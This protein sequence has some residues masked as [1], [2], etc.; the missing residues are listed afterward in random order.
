M[1][2]IVGIFELQTESSLPLPSLAPALRVLTPRGPDGEGEWSGHGCSLGHRRLSIL[3]VKGG[4]QP[5]QDSDQSAGV[6]TYNGELYNYRALRERLAGRGYRFRSDCDT[7]VV[8]AAWESD[9]VRALDDFNGIFAFAWFDGRDRLWLVRD[10]LGA[11]PLYYSVVEGRLFFAST[12]AALLS[13]EEIPRVLDRIAAAH[14]LASARTNLDDR[15]LL[16]DIRILPPGHVLEVRRGQRP[17]TIQPRA[18]W[19]LPPLRAAD[20][21]ELSLE[22]AG[23]ACRE[24][25]TEAVQRQLQSDVPVGAFLSGGLD[26]SI[27]LALSKDLRG[28]SL[29]SYGVEFT[30]AA[31]SE[32]EGAYMR[33]AATALET[34][35]HPVELQQKD[36]SPT[37]EDL[38]GR[39]GL[40]LSTPNEVAIYHLARRLR[41]EFTV[42][43][44][45]EGADEV[46]AGYLLPY[47][48]AWDYARTQDIGYSS[49]LRQRIRDFYG[50]SVFPHMAAHHLSLNVW[51]PPET[52]VG[53]LGSTLEAGW[54]PVAN[55]YRQSLNAVAECS[56][57][58]RYLHLHRRVN[59]EGLLLRLDANTMAAS[60]EGRVPFADREIVEWANTLPDALRLHREDCTRVVPWR[61]HVAADWIQRGWVEGKRVLRSAFAERLP[62]SIVHRPK[63]SFPVPFQNELALRSMDD[64]AWISENRALDG[65]VDRA[66]V[67][68]FWDR[69]EI[70][71]QYFRRWPLINLLRWADKWKVTAS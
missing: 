53:I 52:I 41:A 70:P 25:L 33:E 44:G 32:R 66:A 35:F 7:E 36:F 10:Q 18:Y 5:W 38:I 1:C 13:F 14:Y 28:T 68:A 47:A 65:L 59:L 15:T 62:S 4:Q 31:P 67:L 37:W 60:V 2:G 20:K 19:N 57:L 34:S 12:V 48:S 69:T 24:R 43:L 54:D 71:G 9:G 21:V 56:P 45:G 63:M 58:D 8:H 27:L 42:A 55:Y 30:D 3:D 39:H 22:A 16:A 64:R 46:F 51:S 49:V 29:G 61:D 26:S 17:E 6:L 11:K 23:E 40:P 50:I